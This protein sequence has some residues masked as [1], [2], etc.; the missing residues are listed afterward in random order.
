LLITKIKKRD[1]RLEAFDSDKITNTIQKAFIAVGRRTDAAETS[2]QLSKEIVANLEEKYGSRFIPSVEDV[3]DLVEKTLIQNN[4]ADVA[5]A[6]ILYRSRHQEFRNYRKFIGVDDDLKLNLNALKVLQ[7]RY[8]RRD[9]SG[10]II[11]TPRELFERVAQS[12]TRVDDRY[13]DSKDR[14][15]ATRQEFFELMSKLEFLPNSPTLMNAGTH[16]G[17]LSACFVILIEDDLR[18][19][20][21]AVKA[22]AIIHQSGGGTGFSFSRLRP[23]GDIVK[24]TGGVA[25]GPVSFM[26]VFDAT[27]E[28][29]KQGGRRRGANMAVLSGY[30]P[31]IIEFVASKSDPSV[32]TNFNISVAVDKNFMQAVAANKKSH[33]GTPVMERS[34]GKFQHLNYSS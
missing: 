5:K 31:D 8:L 7:R 32:L 10:K 29:I 2:V 3:Q 30:H 28:E 18:S 23:R 22:T 16:L 13:P 6:Y 26:K 24:T 33:S 4:Y 11:E 15:K 27:T 34:L 9:E 12:I 21:D 1:G 19:I 25:S 14:V 20:F 17:Q